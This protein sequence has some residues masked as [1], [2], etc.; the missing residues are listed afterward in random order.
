MAR[1]RIS[2]N[3][4]CMQ[5]SEKVC[6]AIDGPVASGKSTIGR[7]L[8]RSLGF[9]YLD[10]GAMY[11]GVTA[12]ALTHHLDLHD[13]GAVTALAIT[14]HF[15]FPELEQGDAVNPP[16]FA[17]G[18]DITP[19]LRTPEVDRMVSLVS[20]YAGVRRAL[21]AQQRRIASMRSVVMV[22]R[23]I[24]TVVLPDAE[25]KVFLTASVE[26]RA[27]RRHAERKVAGIN[28]TYEDTLADV[29]RRDLL[30]SERPISP[31]RPAADALVIDTTGLEP[32]QSA[33][34]VLDVVRQKVGLPE[35]A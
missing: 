2:K 16:L 31:L 9:L 24:G 1:D 18:V 4:M 5:A 19:M 11:R 29:R 25:A 15:T 34:V 30:D 10:T 13:E 6:I 14:I 33:Q 12:L 22:G 27:A 7:T 20:S 26:E 8:A 17:D 21:V 3:G 28:E 32:A 35:R 23:D